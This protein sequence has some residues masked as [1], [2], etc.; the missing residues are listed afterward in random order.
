VT[1]ERGPEAIRALGDRFVSRAVDHDGVSKE[2]AHEVFSCMERFSI[3]GF[4]DAHGASFAEL[5]YAS[6]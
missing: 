3:Y 6:A 5:A 4:S 1:R 2:K